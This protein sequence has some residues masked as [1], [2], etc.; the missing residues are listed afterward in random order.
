MEIR[1]QSNEAI[2]AS[3]YTE[4]FSKILGYI[5]ERINDI[6]DAENLAQDVWLRL[7][8]CGKELKADT[9]VSL[10]YTIA[11]NLVN[12]YL[13]RLYRSRAMQEE[14]M[15]TSEEAD[16]YT[17]SRAIARDIAAMEYRRADALPPQRRIIYMMSRYDDKSVD[18]IAC[19]LNLSFRTVENHLRL[20]R[21]DVRSFMAAIA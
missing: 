4:N 10:L 15:L 8:E 13:R 7:L 1:R 12:D 17:E 11:H 21:R 3:S 20:G 16:P 2:I 6:H 5:R 14:I 18:D 9:I 19:E